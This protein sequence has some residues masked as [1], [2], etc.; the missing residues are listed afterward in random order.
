MI[1]P[2]TLPQPVFVA[3]VDLDEAKQNAVEYFKTLDGSYSAFLESDPAVKLIE[4]M[5]YFFAMACRNV[6]DATLN[7]MVAYAVGANLENLVAR[8]NVTRLT[9]T[10]ADPSTYP[11]TPAV[12][13]SDDDLRA[14]FFLSFDG[15]TNAGSK[16]A[17]KFFTMS[18][19]GTIKDARVQDSNEDDFIP[20]VVRVA[21]LTRTGDGT[22]S[23]EIIQKVVNALNAE[24]V[25]PLCDTVRVESANIVNYDVTATLTLYADVAHDEIFATAKQNL[26]DYAA[27]MERLGY[28]ITTAGIIA[29][30]K[31][32]GV[33]NVV[34]TSPAADIPVA[35]NEAA[36]MGSAT[37]NDGGTNE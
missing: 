35:W 31:C 37:I 16:G 23:A 19:D 2:S 12:M 11:P 33:Q 25:R 18:A 6:N 32:D 20:G 24:E 36:Y 14:R 15:F 30:L 27:K 9:I 5:T 10:P 29:A 17:Y 34:L 7:S 26:D 22:A 3:T 28:D 13:E 4:V 21:V 1:D 8:N